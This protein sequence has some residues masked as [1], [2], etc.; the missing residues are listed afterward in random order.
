MGG[1][2][3]ARE[4]VSKAR[5]GGRGKRRVGLVG[6]LDAACDGSLGARRYT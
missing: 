5:T 3:L 6:S 2:E 4:G 1:T